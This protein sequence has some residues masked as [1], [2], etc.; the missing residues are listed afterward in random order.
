M[1]FTP[2][3]LHEVVLKHGRIELAEWRWPDIIDFLK[4]ESELMLEMSVAPYATDA[5]AEF[6]AIA[7]GNRCFMGTMFIRY[8]GVAVHGRGEGGQIRV[9]RFVFSSDTANSILPPME[10]PSLSVLQSLLDIK[11]DSLR[12]LMR[13]AYRELTNGVDQSLEALDAILNLVTIELRRLFERQSQTQRTGRL[14]AWQYRRIRERLTAERAWPT[15]SELARLCGIS[16]RHLHRQ[17][18]SLTG[19]TIAQYIESFQIER[20]KEMLVTNDLPIQ[21]ISF[22]C[23]FSHSSSFAR[24]FRR[25]TG[26][27]PAAFRHRLSKDG[28]TKLHLP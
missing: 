5:S 3:F 1:N 21:S 20:A 10:A 19:S 4:T 24:A 11:S 28:W 14:A 13:L 17:F 23:G 6:P 25:S 2:T 16:P 22:A 18:R 9:V 7:P 26:I 27:A 12:W 8:P 15:A